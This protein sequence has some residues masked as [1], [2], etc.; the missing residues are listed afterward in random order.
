MADLRIGQSESMK[1][2]FSQ[3]DLNRF[4]MLSGDDNPIHVDPDFS[5]RTKFGK[6]VVHGMML[7]SAI[8]AAIGKWFPNGGFIQL[9]QELMFPSP[10]FVNETLEIR[11]E[12]TAFPT[13]DSIE[14]TTAV[15][16]P[17]GEFGCTGKTQILRPEA[18]TRFATPE[19]EN[20]V[21]E[22]GVN[23]H[24]G[25]SLGQ[26]ASRTSIFTG[27]PWG[28]LGMFLALVNDG[29][30]LFWDSDY[31][32]SRGLESVI[33]PGGLLGGMISD[34][35]GTQ[36]PGRGTNWLKQRLSF[37][38]PAYPNATITANVAIV[39]LR[40]EKDLVNLRTTCVDPTGDLVLD[41][42]ALVWVSDLEGRP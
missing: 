17:N 14:I 21:Y 41:G 23:T 18:E 25:L 26:S 36:L 3:E 35:L 40:S 20:P 31:A 39:R 42:E 5:A 28:Q 27:G 22:S 10:T 1:R 19:S 8:C 29:N 2:V 33:L 12:V 24:R 37:P 4:A 9:S 13:L 6:T 32:R 16:K 38:K 7:Y 34:L 11:L 30:L 15:T